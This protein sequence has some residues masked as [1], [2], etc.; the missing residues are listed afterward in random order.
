MTPLEKIRAIAEEYQRAPRW[1]RSQE[2]G[3]MLDEWLDETSEMP[4]DEAVQRFAK[5]AARHATTDGVDQWNEMVD[6][7]NLLPVA[8]QQEL[9]S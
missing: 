1:I 2:V 6:V 4:T 7:W 3:K 9:L 5:V 8:A